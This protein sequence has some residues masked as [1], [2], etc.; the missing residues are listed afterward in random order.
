[1]M[2]QAAG[3]W[4]ILLNAVT[5]IAFKDILDIA[6]I[7]IL[8]YSVIK[9]VKETRA[10]QL[11]KGLIF[12]IVLNWIASQL[13]MVMT[14]RVLNYVFA[15]S[16]AAL[17][18][19][20]QPEIRKALE[21]MGR[22]NVG[23]SVMNLVTGKERETE[24][25]ATLKAIDSVVEATAMLQQKRMGA[26]IVFERNTK[27]D[28]VVKTGT[29]LNAEPTAQLIG[30]IFFNKAPL[31]DG[32][33]IIRGNRV[34]AAGCV[35]PL[36]GQDNVNAAFGT[37]HRAALG[38]SEDTDAIVVVVSEETG[39]IS[40]AF[41]GNLVREYKRLSLREVLRE[42]LIVHPE[43]E[44]IQGSKRLLRKMKLGSRKRRAEKDE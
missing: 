16:A 41:N 2:E 31:H 26:L 40:V 1:M 19:L 11:V 6:I 25:A 22:G 36:T 35:L 38:I 18:I 21:Q 9:L 32:A 14:N 3:F 8:I 20:F 34:L 27:L 15:I 23:K 24:D 28:E 37:R 43:E 5:D 29:V 12:L 10:G 39:H 4:K 42:K 30:N 17:I 33:M 13:N 7:A 44:A